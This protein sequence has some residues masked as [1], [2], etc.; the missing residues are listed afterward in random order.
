MDPRRV[1]IG[2]SALAAS[3]AVIIFVVNVSA[4]DE[5]N[6]NSNSMLETGDQ[7]ISAFFEEIYERKVAQSPNLQSSLGR[8]TDRLGEWDDFS[9]SFV[10]E[11]NAETALDLEK[12]RSQFDYDSLSQDFKLSYEIFVFNAE[13]AMRDASFSKHHYVVDQFN[14]QLSG[15]LAVLKK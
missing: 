11:R 2:L 1:V 4:P 5:V 3:V 7:R 8:Q 14:G 12:L 6:S 15:L 13:Q 10:A 9:D